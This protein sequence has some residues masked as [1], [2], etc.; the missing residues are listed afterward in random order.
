MMSQ[1][2]IHSNKLTAHESGD[3]SMED[4]SLVSKSFFSSAESDKVLTGLGRGGS[5]HA[6]LDAP[7]GLTVDANVEVDRVGNVR[8]L[9]TK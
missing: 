4:A 7:S 6:H 2:V 5:V 1:P 3:N 8:G 9:L